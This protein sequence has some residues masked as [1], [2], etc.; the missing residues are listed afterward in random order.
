[1]DTNQN[2]VSSYTYDAYGNIINITGEIGHINPYRYRSYYYDSE[3][4]LYY[5]NARYYNPLTSRWISQDKVDYLNPYSTIGLNL[6]AYCNNNPIM[7]IDPS[8]NVPWLAI[9]LV[10]LAV[11]V[12]I[13]IVGVAESKCAKDEYDDN[14]VDNNANKVGFEKGNILVNGSPAGTY[15]E[16]GNYVITNSYLYCEEDMKFI[17]KAISKHMGDEGAYYRLYNEWESHNYGYYAFS[18]N[19]IFGWANDLFNKNKDSDWIDSS[20]SVDFGVN[21]E[22]EFRNI[23]LFLLRFWAN[24]QFYFI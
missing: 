16:N 10:V 15:S 21:E 1:M 13:D 23:G 9:G 20:T 8:G 4:A 5:C 24:R 2:I 3:T 6:Y 17:C 22:T 12:L 14:K 19:F 7:N 11:V 18:D